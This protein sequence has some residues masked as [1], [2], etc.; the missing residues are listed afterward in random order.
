MLS[1]ISIA[2]TP[3]SLEMEP[4]VAESGDEGAHTISVHSNPTSAE[5]WQQ[6]QLFEA[7]NEDY[8]GRVCVIGGGEE[9]NVLSV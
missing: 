3:A 8:G 7:C 1:N 9:V 6:K 5:S 4:R 2:H